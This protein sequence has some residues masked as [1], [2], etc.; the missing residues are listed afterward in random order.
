MA[1]LFVWLG[2]VNKFESR[3]RF[4]S[5]SNSNNSSHH[6]WRRRLRL[7][8]TPSD[9]R[10][11]TVV[12]FRVVVMK[13]VFFRIANATHLFFG[14]APFYVFFRLYQVREPVCASLFL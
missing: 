6:L 7:R 5:S 4:S 8:R 12:L 11:C 10:G 1:N 14:H 9:V 2:K 13:T 3:N